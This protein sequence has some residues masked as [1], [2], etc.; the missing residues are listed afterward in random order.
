MNSLFAPNFIS[1]FLKNIPLDVVLA[2]IY[3]EF[4]LRCFSSFKF[5]TFHFNVD[6]L[7]DN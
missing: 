3:I 6:F 4:A 7:K 1:S 5:Y 2:V